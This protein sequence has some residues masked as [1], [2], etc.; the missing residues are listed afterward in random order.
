M[1][2]AEETHISGVLLH[3]FLASQEL[4][5]EETLHSLMN[6]TVLTPQDKPCAVSAPNHNSLADS[7][8][9]TTNLSAHGDRGSQFNAKEEENGDNLTDVTL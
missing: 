2:K 8:I 7:F 9:Q 5:C 3:T 6:G 1:V 4:S